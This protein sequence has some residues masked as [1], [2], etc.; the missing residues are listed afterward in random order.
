[1]RA[2]SLLSLTAWGALASLG[3]AE[4]FTR[5]GVEPS[6]SFRSLA[7]EMVEDEA[8]SDFDRDSRRSILVDTYFHV[9]SAS[10]SGSAQVTVRT[11]PVVS[12]L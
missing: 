9:V 10:E 12:L 4:K 3:V 1:M 5:C 11:V 8:R 6:E 2:I 7:A